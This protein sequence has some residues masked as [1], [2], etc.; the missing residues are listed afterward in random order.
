MGGQHCC[1]CCC[2]C[3][4]QLLLLLISLHFACVHSLFCFA[5]ARPR[6]KASQ[7]FTKYKWR[8]EAA[9][10]AAGGPAI[11]ATQVRIMRC[12]TQLESH[13][14][15]GRGDGQEPSVLAVNCGQDVTSPRHDT[16]TAFCR[17]INRTFPNLITY[18]HVCCVTCNCYN[19]W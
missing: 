18:M 19:R 15:Q 12:C 13:A 4:C 1:C 10:E 2:C 16:V 6:V 5:A 7:C 8:D 9:A 14:K 3:S 11:V 17:L